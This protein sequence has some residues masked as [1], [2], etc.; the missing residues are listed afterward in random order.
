MRSRSDN[1]TDHLR[2]IRE[3]SRTVSP[4]A[5]IQAAQVAVRQMGVDPSRASSAT[6]EQDA[7][8]VRQ[9]YAGALYWLC[10]MSYVAVGRR[11]GCG[12]ASAQARI[13]AFARLKDREAILER[14]RAVV[15]RMPQ[16][17]P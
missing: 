5:A 2:T 17:K 11:V 9:V 10:R 14:I 1:I 6:R 8:F 15:A 4:E 12:K 16:D 13:A 3:S 7:V